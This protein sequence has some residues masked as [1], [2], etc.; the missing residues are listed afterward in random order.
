MAKEYRKELRQFG[1]AYLRWAA[2]NQSIASSSTAAGRAWPYALRRMARRYPPIAE[3]AIKGTADEKNAIKRAL[4]DYHWLVV[5]RA[6]SR[7]A[8]AA[9]IVVI[10]IVLL[11]LWTGA[12][13]TETFVDALF[14]SIWWGAPAV[15][16]AGF[17]GRM[18]QECRWEVARRVPRSVRERLRK[19][20]FSHFMADRFSFGAVFLGVCAFLD[21]QWPGFSR[22][23]VLIAVPL[24]QLLGFVDWLRLWRAITR[25]SAPRA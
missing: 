4:S 19:C 20:V 25:R 24:G 18:R 16:T 6:G 9:T 22:H 5:A 7:A 11:V 2:Y 8:G 21:S 15:V 23:G 13:P 10:A 17:V 12:S 14:S 3:A 1:E